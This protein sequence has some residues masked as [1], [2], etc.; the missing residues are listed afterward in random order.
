M[1]VLLSALASGLLAVVITLG[2]N[3][4]VNWQKVRGV[5]GVLREEIEV[6]ADMART[7]HGAG[8]AAPLYRLPTSSY[9]TGLRELL[10]AGAIAGAAAKALILFYSEVETLNRGLDQAADVSPPDAPVGTATQIVH[11]RNRIKAEHIR[12]SDGH[13]YLA[14]MRAVAR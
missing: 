1:L 4:L 14:A 12:A 2:N 3:W 13:L 6:C 7:F 11:D 5:R 9:Y 8:I 10:A